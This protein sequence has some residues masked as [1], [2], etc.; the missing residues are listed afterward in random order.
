MEVLGLRTGGLLHT[1]NPNQMRDP[2]FH[3]PAGFEP[4]EATDGSKVEV[5]ATIEMLDN[6]RARLTAVDGKE[7][8]DKRSL[9]E[10]LDDA[11]DGPRPLASD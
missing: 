5:M 9:I 3:L 10:T 11:I 7:I 2:V 1:R 4:P 6:G 8:V